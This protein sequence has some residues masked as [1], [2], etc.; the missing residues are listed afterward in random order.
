MKYIFSLAMLLILT[1][2]PTLAQTRDGENRIEFIRTRV[3]GT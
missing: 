2:S 3:I 1:S